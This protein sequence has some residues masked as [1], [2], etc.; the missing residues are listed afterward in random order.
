MLATSL[1]SKD[2]PCL[3]KTVNE[4]LTRRI[5]YYRDKADTLE[6][7][8]ASTPQDLL[9][10]TLGQCQALGIWVDDY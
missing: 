5:Q 2:E 9:D 3:K 7:Q 10:M 1:P 6:S 8:L 4:A